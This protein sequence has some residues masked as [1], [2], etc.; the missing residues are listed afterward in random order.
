MG[1]THAFRWA[2]SVKHN[3]VSN[4]AREGANWFPTASGMG[5][6]RK[7]V[8]SVQPCRQSFKEVEPFKYQAVG[9]SGGTLVNSLTAA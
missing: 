1:T 7:V 3:R 6:S 8:G 5:A 9:G 2:Y 4:T